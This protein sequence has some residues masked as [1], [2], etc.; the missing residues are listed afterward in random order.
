MIDGK[1]SLVTTKKHEMWWRT[2]VKEPDVA[3]YPK[4]F[5]MGN[6]AFFEA[7]ILICMS[8]SNR[9]RARFLNCG[10]FYGVLF[11]C[12]S[13]YEFFCEALSESRKV[14]R[15]LKMRILIDKKLKKHKL[16]E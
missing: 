6:Q 9:V 7:V 15:G 2:K 3:Y 8:R 10:L 1:N 16:N 4:L 13:F 11:C 14:E 5:L 12:M